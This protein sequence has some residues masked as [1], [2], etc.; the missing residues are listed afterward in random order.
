MG[1]FSFIETFFFLSLAVSFVLILLLVYHF[2]KHV[3][4]LERKYDTVVCIINDIAKEMTMM[5]CGCM[6]NFPNDGNGYDGLCG[7]SVSYQE[8]YGR[9]P[10]VSG[11]SAS[12]YAIEEIEGD[13]SSDDDEDSDEDSD[14]DDSDDSVVDDADDSDADN[15]D[16]AERTEIVHKIVVSD[17]DEPVEILDISVNIEPELTPDLQGMQGMQGTEEVSMSYSQEDEPVEDSTKKMSLSSLKQL[18]LSKGLTADSS[19]MKKSE[20]LQLLS[21]SNIVRGDGIRLNN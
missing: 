18:V 2:K 21:A 8:D 15:E 14:A 13:D 12:S 11:D 17:T 7:I 1:I 20:L 5:K 6:P 16:T 4:L 3:S 9:N 19:K 10:P